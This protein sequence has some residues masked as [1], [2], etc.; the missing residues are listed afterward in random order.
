MSIV[1]IEPYGQ[2]NVEGLRAAAA[3]I[4]DAAL[5][6]V[7]QEPEVDGDD[8]TRVVFVQQDIQSVGQRVFR[9]GDL[10]RKLPQVGIS[11]P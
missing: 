9:E 5:S 8:R 6:R 10:H 1:V 11:L 4:E 7:L 3:E 2:G